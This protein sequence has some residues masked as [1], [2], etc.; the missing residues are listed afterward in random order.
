MILTEPLE[1][2]ARQTPDKTAVIDSGGNQTASYS[3]LNDSTGKFAAYLADKGITKGD[4]VIIIG[5]NSIEFIIAMYG[6]LKI[7]AVF[8]PLQSPKV[9][10]L[11]YIKEDSQCKAVIKTEMVAEVIGGYS[12]LP[13][14][15]HASLSKEDISLIIYTSGTTNNPKGVVEPHSAV[16]F[17]VRSINKIIKNTSKDRILCGLPMSFDYGLYQIFLSFDTGATLVLAQSLQNV[18]ALPSLLAKCQITGFPLLPSVAAAIIRSKLLER[19]PL[20][21]LRYITSTGDTFHTNHIEK[22]MEV[23]PNVSIFPMYGLTECKRV[24]ILSPSD[25][26]GHEK[27]VGKPIPGTSAYVIDT[28]GNKL[29]ENETGIL[30]VSGP[31]VMSGYLNED[32][33]TSGRF[34]VDKKSGEKSL[35]TN[36]YFRIDGQGFLYYIGRDEAVIKSSGH[37]I[38]ISEIES[39]IAQL[40]SVAEVCAVGVDDANKGQVVKLHIYSHNNDLTEEAVRAQFYA[41]FS[42]DV[43]MQKIIFH[44]EALPKTA[45]GKLDRIALRAF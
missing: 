31:H 29:N 15:H 43:V 26:K 38:G 16:S 27:S 14:K 18:I 20:P 13:K 41:Y 36:D 44:R 42:E 33:K 4:R 39:V 37:R 35:I 24:S 7:G 3:E 34:F 30:V 17:A 40:S 28:N 32:G 6:C 1:F 10:R 11:E 23:L 2:Y 12:T 45:N 19:T 5:D 22:L 21:H 25:Y 8:I 9:A